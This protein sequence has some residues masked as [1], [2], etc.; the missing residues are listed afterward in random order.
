[1]PFA[2]TC[3]A[4]AVSSLDFETSWLAV[5]SYQSQMQ[6][7]SSQATFSAALSSPGRQQGPQEPWEAS[8]RL[9]LGPRLREEEEDVHPPG[10]IVPREAVGEGARLAVGGGEEVG[11]VAA[12]GVEPAVDADHCLHL[13]W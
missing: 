11:G 9:G 12:E 10:P 3:T 5:P 6:L 4:V 13:L 1:M 7:L 2:P 8:L